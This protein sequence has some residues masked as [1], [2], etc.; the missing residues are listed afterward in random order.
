VNRAVLAATSALSCVA[1]ALGV[2]TAE[3]DLERLYSS[4]QWFELRSSVTDRSPDLIRSAVA[5]VFN[6]PV[7]AEVLLRKVIREQPRSAAANDAYGMLSQ[8]FIRSGQYERFAK[9]YSEWAASFPESDALREERENLEKF[10]GRPDQ[11]NPPRRRATLR[12][13]DDS[14]SVPVTINGRSDDFLFD[15]GAWQSV[16]T[17][18]EAKKLGLTVRE[19]TKTLTDAS[20]TLTTFRTAVAGEVLIG[21]MRFRKVSFAVLTGGPFADAEV[22]VVGMP[23]LLAVGGLRWSKDGIVELGGTNGSA[24]PISPNLVFDRHRLMLAADVLGKRVLTTLDTGASTT[25]LN[26]N[27]AD[28]FP[29]VVA[30][31]K[32]GT[33]DI[34]GAGGTQTFDSIELPEMTFTIGR[35]SVALR[36]ANVTLQRLALIGGKCCVGNA[37]HDLL[38]QQQRFTIDFSKMTLELQ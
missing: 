23:I 8:I 9:N 26:A 35:T 28:L 36:P 7:A 6:E 15:T 38:T 37:G 1:V 29:D 17:E 33:Q 19:G 27:F 14:F 5:T 30:R 31:G 11:L 18:K 22:G 2:Q 16:L 13:S 25:D 3:R 34:T 10:R 32:K 4:R 20:G 24:A 21:E 12:H